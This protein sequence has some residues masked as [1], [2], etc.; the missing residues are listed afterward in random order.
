M[1][2][3]TAKTVVT[4]ALVLILGTA[5]MAQARGGDMERGSGMR[6][7]MMETWFA[8]VDTDGDGKIT[9][10]EIDAFKQ[11]R[12]TAADTDKD[13]F[14][15]AEEMSAYADKAR[16]EREA[17]RKAARA[18]AMLKRMDTDQDGKISAEEAAAMGPGQDRM[19]KKLDA[20]E[21][22][23]VSLEEIQ[24]A[25]S[26]MRHWGGKRGDGG[27]RQH[28]RWNGHDKDHG[29]ERGHGRMGGGDRAPWWMQ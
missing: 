29:G 2:M 14:L 27:E 19:L 1:T 10:A 22:G 20:D 3:K 6:G 16:A 18:D 24:S 5:G 11:A 4:G 25:Q 8:Q 15:S 17:A 7:A 9:P 28:S 23:A 13:G 12:F 21:D 26:K